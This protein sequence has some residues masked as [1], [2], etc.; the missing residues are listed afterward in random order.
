MD[1]P[2]KMAGSSEGAAPG[3]GSD[4]LRWL[5]RSKSIGLPPARFDLTG[6]ETCPTFRGSLKFLLTDVESF[7]KRGDL[8]PESRIHSPIYSYSKRVIL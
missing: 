7:D 5:G 1:V 3:L 8:G 2:S 6:R 4:R